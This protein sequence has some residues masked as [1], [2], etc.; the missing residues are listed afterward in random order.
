MSASL[1]KN[2]GSA[3]LLTLGLSLTQNGLLKHSQIENAHQTAM[4]HVLQQR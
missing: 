4:Q 3:L 1:V 2:P